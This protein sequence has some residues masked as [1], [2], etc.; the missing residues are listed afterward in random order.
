MPGSHSPA[1]AGK[2]CNDKPSKLQMPLN[3]GT[4]PNWLEAKIVLEDP[5]DFRRAGKTASWR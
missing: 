4:I 5:N 3:V 1:R 2:A